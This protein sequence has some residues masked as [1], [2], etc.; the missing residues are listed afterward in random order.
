[1]KFLD[2]IT[3]S[4]NKVNEWNSQQFSEYVTRFV[5]TWHIIT[6]FSNSNLIHI[7]SHVY[8]LEKFQLNMP[9][10]FGVIYTPAK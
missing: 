4:I 2:F 5:K 8:A 1:M 3:K 7:Y 9:N 6:K 10:A